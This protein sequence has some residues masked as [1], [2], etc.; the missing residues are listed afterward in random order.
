MQILLLWLTTIVV[1]KGMN[2]ITLGRILKDIYENGYKINIKKLVEMSNMFNN[3]SKI[4][5]Y[6]MFL[7]IFDAINMGMTYI[8]DPNAVLN[9]FFMNDALDEMNEEEKKMYSEKP[10]MIRALYISALADEKENIKNNIIENNGLKDTIKVLYKDRGKTSI[11]LEYNSVNNK[12]KVDKINII[13][14]IKSNESKE[15][16]ASFIINSFKVYRKIANYPIKKE[17]LIKY[18]KLV[19]KKEKIEI[20][21]EKIN[22]SEEEKRLEECSKVVK[23]DGLILSDVSHNKSNNYSEVVNS[24]AE[25]IEEKPVVL[26]RKKE[27]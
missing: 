13:T 2:Y 23:H 25:E 21:E 14:D 27:K 12:I 8:K 18:I 4:R 16:Y 7:N 3:T 1:S 9:F 20:I 26:T 19:N 10:N 15:D 6:I 5:Q 17:R 24:N 11:N 22:V